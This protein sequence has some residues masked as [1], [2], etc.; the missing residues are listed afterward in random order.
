MGGGWSGPR[1]GR[2]TPGKD[3]VPT[4]KHVAVL[5]MYKILFIYIFCEFVGADNKVYE[6]DGTYIR[7][8]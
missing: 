3:P 5:T 4:V 1:P 8:L 7:M 6:M 2:F